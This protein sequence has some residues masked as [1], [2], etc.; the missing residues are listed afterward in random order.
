MH[1]TPS[2]VCDGCTNQ[3]RRATPPPGILPHFASL[4]GSVLL[5][6]IIPPPP[7]QPQAQK[8]KEQT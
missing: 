7:L 5:L 4:T 6:I 2:E 1:V 3:T 8:T